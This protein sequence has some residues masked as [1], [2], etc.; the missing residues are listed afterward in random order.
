M[1]S[2]LLSFFPCRLYLCG[3]SE[4]KA[5]SESRR[6]D[7]EAASLQSGTTKSIFMKDQRGRGGENKGEDGERPSTTQI[8]VQ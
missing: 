6:P 2:S 3:P 1:I 4:N 5:A 8:S 7:C